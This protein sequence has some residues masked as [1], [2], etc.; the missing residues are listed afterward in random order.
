MKIVF[1]LATP[2]VILLYF[3]FCFYD[4]HQLY[5]QDVDKL[6]SVF[7]LATP[8]VIYFFCSFLL[9]TIFL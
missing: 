2:Y 3:C 4:K 6:L 5:I 1:E 9:L 7:E 8:Q